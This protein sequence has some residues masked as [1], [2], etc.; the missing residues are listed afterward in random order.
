LCFL[1]AVGNFSSEEA[2]DFVAALH[3]AAGANSQLLLATDQWKDAEVLRQAYDD[4]AGAGIGRRWKGN[5][6]RREH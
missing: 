4:S 1:A 3:S 5:M 2:A 6:G